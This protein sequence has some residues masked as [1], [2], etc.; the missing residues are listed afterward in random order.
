M[1][2]RLCVPDVDLRQSLEVCL[3]HLWP[4]LSDGC[5]LFTHEAAHREIASLFFDDA[6]WRL[7][8]G[9]PAP[10]LVG[11]GS[12]LE[13]LPVDGSFRSDLAYTI[14]GPRDLRVVAG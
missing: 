8:L 7:N 3:N 2:G 11:A 13:L 10:G 6:W 5:Y 9:C 4:R 1:R 14:K 12:G